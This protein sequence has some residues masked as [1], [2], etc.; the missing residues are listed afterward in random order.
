MQVTDK[1]N[2]R[3]AKMTFASVFPLYVT[4]VES[5]GRTKDELYLVIKWL[6]GF[7]QSKIQE[8]IDEN[9]TFEVFF[10]RASLNPNAEL[11]TGLICG[12]RIEEIENPLTKK[13]RY[14]DKII[15]ELAKGRKIEKILRQ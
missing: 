14:L 4:K 6:T 3:I 1:H 10:E 9:A 8:L 13:V 11:I 2:E 7:D 15:D 5:K 12:Y